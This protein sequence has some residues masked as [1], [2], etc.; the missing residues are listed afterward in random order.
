[1]AANKPPAVKITGIRGSIPSGYLLGRTS[2]GSGDV[3]LISL[4]K[5]QS[6]GLSPTKLPP[7]GPA[8]GDLGGTFPNPSV[9]GLQGRAVEATAPTDGQVLTWV[10]ADNA[11]EP[12]TPV[13]PSGGTLFAARFIDSAG[14]EWQAVVLSDTNPIVVVDV[15]GRP[16]YFAV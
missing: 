5:A 2:G 13:A 8:G 6:A 16:M 9:I 12:A 7:T 4:A 3:E 15:D 14:Q 11:W 1:M 10:A